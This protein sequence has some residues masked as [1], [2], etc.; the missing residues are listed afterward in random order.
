M[1]RPYLNSSL[2]SCACHRTSYKKE[3]VDC[4][5]PKWFKWWIIR[6]AINNPHYNP[7]LPTAS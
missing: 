3:I 7:T 5:Q 6:T 4:P 2:C 1:E